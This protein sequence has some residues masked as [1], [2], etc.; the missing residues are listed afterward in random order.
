MSRLTIKNTHQ[1]WILKYF[2]LNNKKICAQQL[3]SDTQ[4]SEQFSSRAM[5]DKDI[6]FHLVWNISAPQKASKSPFKW[7]SRFEIIKGYKN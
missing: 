7:Q 3:T 6:Q 1:D 2:E 4:I 5:G